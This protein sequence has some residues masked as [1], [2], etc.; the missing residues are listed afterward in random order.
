[1]AEGEARAPLR[2]AAPSTLSQSRPQQI[3]KRLR[4]PPNKPEQSH[5]AVLL[6]ADEARWGSFGTVP[7]V[8]P[9]IQ[10]A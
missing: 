4:R 3:L 1:V 7:D 8:I 9:T 10:S 2:R 5:F 6:V